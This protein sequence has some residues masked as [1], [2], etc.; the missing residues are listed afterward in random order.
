[1]SVVNTEP[2]IINAANP[3]LD[4]I[5]T[6]RESIQNNVRSN[7]KTEFGI[8]VDV[9]RSNKPGISHGD[10]QSYRNLATDFI[11]K[12]SSQNQPSKIFQGS[13]IINDGETHDNLFN[14]Y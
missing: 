12:E 4:I 6:T 5:E 14:V 9:S 10:S 11:A 8:D 2:A 3:G 13:T 7:S 1:M